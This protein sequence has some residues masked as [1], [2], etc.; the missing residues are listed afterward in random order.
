MSFR[1][2]EGPQHMGTVSSLVGVLW[3][4][5]S[6]ELPKLSGDQH[7]HVARNR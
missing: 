4:P 5:A 6:S 3:N 1:A 2:L 7:R